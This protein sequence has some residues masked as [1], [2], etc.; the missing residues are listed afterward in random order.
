[1]DEREQRWLNDLASDDEATVVRALHR[2]CP[3]SGSAD[4][5][6]RYKH[7]L[8]ALKKDARPE[9]RQVALH[10]EVDALDQLTVHDEQ[11]NGFFRGRPDAWFRGRELRS[12]DMR[13]GYRELP[14]ANRRRPR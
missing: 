14:K 2:A 5:Y 7:Q 3:C 8:H 9:V 13:E 10:L 12:T 4:L 11:A 1:M 6:M